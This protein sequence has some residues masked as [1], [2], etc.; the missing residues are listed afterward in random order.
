[1]CVTRYQQ[2]NNPATF[3]LIFAEEMIRQA[4]DACKRNCLFLDWRMKVLFVSQR[5]LDSFAW[6][7]A[8]LMA[9]GAPVGPEVGP[10]REDPDSRGQEGAETHPPKSART[11]NRE[12]ERGWDHLGYPPGQLDLLSLERA[13]ED[14]G[15]DE[16][17]EEE[18]SPELAPRERL[19]WSR[20][21]GS[22]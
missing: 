4:F 13:L 19:C 11:P 2:K 1:M 10:D 12:Q 9:L 6:L 22:C 5:P 16:E 3:H 18:V 8:E 15:D 21:V 17:E 7:G 20:E 14:V